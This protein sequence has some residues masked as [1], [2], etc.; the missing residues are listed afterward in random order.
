MMLANCSDESSLVD[1]HGT[2]P[3]DTIRYRH[4]AQCTWTTF[5]ITLFFWCSD[6]L[7]GWF[8]HSCSAFA[9]H[10]DYSHRV[11]LGRIQSHKM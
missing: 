10:R 3:F 5:A 1:H 11:L 2:L 8:Q 7:R 6:R 4:S 9:D